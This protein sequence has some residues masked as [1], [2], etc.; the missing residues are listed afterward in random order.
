MFCAVGMLGLVSAQGGHAAQTLINDPISQSVTTEQ[1]CK[2]PI[3]GVKTTRAPF[4]C[5]M[6]RLLPI[7][8]QVLSIGQGAVIQRTQG[9]KG[10]ELGENSGLALQ[11]GSQ[12]V[13]ARPSRV[14]VRVC[15][16]GC[17][18]IASAHYHITPYIVE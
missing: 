2:R 16:S 8:C 18:C 5:E 17:V 13:H 9:H 11:E 15:V 14:C 10:L 3:K 4:R 1:T 6:V 7:L 12:H